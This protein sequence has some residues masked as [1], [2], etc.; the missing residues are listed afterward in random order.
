MNKVY[1][2]KPNIMDKLMKVRENM[3]EDM[4]EQIKQGFRAA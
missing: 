4:Q 1:E 3:E 2:E